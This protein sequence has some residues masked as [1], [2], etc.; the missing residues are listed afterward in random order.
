MSRRR[1]DFF[2]ELAKGLQNGPIC[3]DECSDW[4]R[5]DKG[6]SRTPLL[7]P[8]ATTAGEVRREDSSVA[9]EEQPNAELLD[10]A[11]FLHVPHSG[12][13]PGSSR[14]MFIAL[15]SH[16]MRAA[17]RPDCK[18]ASI[19]ISSADVWLHHLRISCQEVVKEECVAK[20]QLTDSGGGDRTK[21]DDSERSGRWRVND[22]DAQ[23]RTNSFFDEKFK[24]MT[25][26]TCKHNVLLKK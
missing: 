1:Q 5:R 15:E 11:S 10:A 3:S 21:H 23:F 13:G 18:N 9:V 20:D 25:L 8:V 4:M 19:T 14:R 22:Y 2:A 6:H 7:F 12:H 17:A 16:I 26:I 24:I